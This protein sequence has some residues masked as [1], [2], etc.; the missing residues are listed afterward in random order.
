MSWLSLRKPTAAAHDQLEAG[1]TC[2]AIGP[3]PHREGM[4]Q[5]REAPSSVA[6]TGLELVVAMKLSELR[7]D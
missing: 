5:I 3:L 1:V 2:A 7:T 6:M 4:L